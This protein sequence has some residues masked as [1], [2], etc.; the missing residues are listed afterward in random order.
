MKN[1]FES[2]CGIGRRQYE[3]STPAPLYK[4]V[5][6]NKPAAIMGLTTWIGLAL[7]DVSGDECIAAY[8]NGDA[9]T[10]AHRHAIAYTSAGRPY[11]RKGG[12]RYYLDEFLRIA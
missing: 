2:R 5:N 8:S 11:I 7:W 3:T 4:Y 12:S 9:Y 10:G 6:E 1:T